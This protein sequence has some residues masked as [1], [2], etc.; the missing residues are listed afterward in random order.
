M[1]SVLF[2]LLLQ[3]AR[4]GI[5]PFALRWLPRVQPAPPLAPGRCRI[6]SSP[7]AASRS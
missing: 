2:I 5:V 7:S 4:A 3:R 1:F 6:A